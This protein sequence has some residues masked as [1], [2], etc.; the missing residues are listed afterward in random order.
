MKKIVLLIMLAISLF[1]E[2]L[3]KEIRI[4]YSYKTSDCILTTFEQKQIVIKSVNDG[5]F[6]VNNKFKLDNGVITSIEGMDKNGRV[7]LV[8]TDTLEACIA[9]REYIKINKKTSGK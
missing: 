5:V 1:G 7:I 3:T 2:L 6:L 9:Y 8:F 4:L